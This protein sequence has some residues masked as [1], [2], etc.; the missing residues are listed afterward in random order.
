MATKIVLVI[1]MKTVRVGVQYSLYL[2]GN[3][4]L[5]KDGDQVPSQHNL[6]KVDLVIY[7][8]FVT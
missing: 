7:G 5:G 8:L 4:F 1:G 3:T 2:L 6:A